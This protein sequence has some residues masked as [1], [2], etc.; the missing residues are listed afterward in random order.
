[1]P[2]RPGRNAMPRPE[3]ASRAESR[4]PL[5]SMAERVTWTS[6]ASPAEG[7][8]LPASRNGSRPGRSAPI[9]TNAASRPGSIDIT[10]PR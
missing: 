8:F 1:M 5:P 2:L 6:I 3:M 7:G 10:R 9:S 4:T